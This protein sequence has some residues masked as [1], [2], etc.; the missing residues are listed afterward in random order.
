MATRHG[1]SHSKASR[2]SSARAST[3]GNGDEDENDF[4]EHPNAEK[5]EPT[6]VRCLPYVY[7]VDKID[8]ITMTSFVH[9]EIALRWADPRVLEEATEDGATFWRVKEGLLEDPEDCED[10]GWG[11]IWKPNIILNNIPSCM[12]IGIPIHTG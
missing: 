6:I 4:S 2:R 5:E 10:D 11:K 3:T 7:K 9:V 12:G 1:R 8:P